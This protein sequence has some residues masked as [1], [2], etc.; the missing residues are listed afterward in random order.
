MIFCY[1][2]SLSAFDF[3]ILDCLAISWLIFLGNIPKSM[4]PHNHANNLQGRTYLGILTYN[5]ARSMQ[6]YPRLCMVLIKAI[7]N[8]IKF[9]IRRGNLPQGIFPIRYSILNLCINY[10]LEYLN[11]PHLEPREESG[12]GRMKSRDCLALR[13]LFEGGFALIV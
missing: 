13:E 11:L 5:M 3:L 4:F 10:R 1:V 2:L 9:R 12:S 8:L 6:D 7:S